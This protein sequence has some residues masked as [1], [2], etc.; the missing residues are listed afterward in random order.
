[1]PHYAQ[2]DKGFGWTNCFNITDK[3]VGILGLY[4]SPKLS[5]CD[6]VFGG[7][8]INARTKDL[9]DY[10][11]EINGQTIPPVTIKISQEMHREIAFLHS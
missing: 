10:L 4:W 7:G 2:C 5:D 1:M 3:T 8:D 6:L 11:P 9:L